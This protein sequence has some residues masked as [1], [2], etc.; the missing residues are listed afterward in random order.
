MDTVQITPEM[1]QAIRVEQCT[2]NGHT[3]D[4]LVALGV[5]PV[6]VLCTNC[7]EVWAVERKP[8]QP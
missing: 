2:Y 4:V 6:Q 8:R 7:G 1:R 5:G 3:F